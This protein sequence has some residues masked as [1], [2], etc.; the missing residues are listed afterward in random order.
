MLRELWQGLVSDGQQAARSNRMDMPSFDTLMRLAAF[1]R[2]RGLN[3]IHD[4]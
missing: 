2:V 3:G 4:H 1:E